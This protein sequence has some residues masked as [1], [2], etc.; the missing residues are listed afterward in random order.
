LTVAL[1]LDLSSGGQMLGTVAGPGWTGALRAYRAAPAAPGTYTLMIPPA[2]GG[3]EGASPSGYG[4]GTITVDKSGNFSLVG[5]LAD[6]SK[7]SQSA[8]RSQ[9]GYWPVYASLYGGSGCALSWVKF[10]EAGGKACAG[11]VVWLTPAGAPSSYPAG[12]TNLN[13]AAGFAYSPA[14]ALAG[15]SGGTLVATN[16]AGEQ[17]SAAGFT[18]DSKG[19]VHPST[20]GS[21]LNLSLVSSSG[22]FKGSV[23]SAALNRAVNFQGVLAG[24][25]TGGWGYFFVS[26]QESGKVLLGLGQ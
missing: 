18:L 14:G 3:G 2:Q 9:G 5:V 10:G 25:G 23:W 4:S 22:V 12:F 26:P 19:H 15:V 7:I 1:R 20:K 24:D 6:G 11:D 8:M 13:A 21:E 16:G 17:I